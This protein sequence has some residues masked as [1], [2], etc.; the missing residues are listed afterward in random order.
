MTMA[1]T[2]HMIA[3]LTLWRPRVFINLVTVFVIFASLYHVAVRS[4]LT[5]NTTLIPV[6]FAME[7]TEATDHAETYLAAGNFV[8]NS[9]IF[10]LPARGFL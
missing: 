6:A 8:W 10:L 5:G 1:V 9:G 4:T 2:A 7:F 3:R